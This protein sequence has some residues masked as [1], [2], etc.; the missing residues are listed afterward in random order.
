MGQLLRHFG[1]IDDDQAEQLKQSLN[2]TLKNWAGTAVGKIT[3]ASLLDE[4]A[5]F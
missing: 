5:P 1:I 3:A 4:T 2:P